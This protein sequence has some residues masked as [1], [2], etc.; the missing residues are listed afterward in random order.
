MNGTTTTKSSVSTG[1]DSVLVAPSVKL[2]RLR[3]L[4]LAVLCFG[5]VGTGIEL[6]LLEHTEDTL[7]WVP[8]ILL[9]VGLGSALAL[10]MR[11][12]R[13]TLRVFRILMVLFIAAGITGVYLHYKG[14]VEF[15]LEMYPTM[16][17]FK[18]IWEALRGATP[19]LAPGTMALFGLI[20]LTTTYAHPAARAGRTGIPSEEV[21]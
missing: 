21:S 1:A 4:I 17:G 18:L 20:G 2:H 8:L 3:T 14:N 16:S 6:F 10:A 19:S 15:E 7:Q 12:S 13:S 11:A 9:A 5:M